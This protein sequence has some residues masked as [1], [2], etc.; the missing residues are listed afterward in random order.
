GAGAGA[1]GDVAD[2]AAAAGDGVEDE[3][4]GGEGGVGAGD[5]VH[6]GEA[7]HGLEGVAEDAGEGF[8][9]PLDVAVGGGDDDEVVGAAGDEGEFAGG[10][11]AGAKGGLGGFAFGDV[12]EGADDAGGCAVVVPGDGAGAGVDPAPV[13]VGAAEAVFGGYEGFFAAFDLLDGG[14]VG[15]EVVG[16]DAFGPFVNGGDG[17]VVGEAEEGPEAGVDVEFGAAGGPFEDADLGGVEG[18]AEALVGE[19]EAFLDAAA[20]LV[21]FDELAVGA[22]GG[23]HAV[24]GGAGEVDA[25]AEEEGD[26]E[27]GAEGELGEV[28][29]GVADVAFGG[30]EFDAQ[31]AVVD[32]EDG[33]E[34]VAG[35][36]AVV[37]GGGAVEG[38][39]GDGEGEVVAV[40]DAEVAVDG[41]EEARVVVTGGGVT[42]EDAALIDGG[43]DDEAGLAG[44]VAR[45]AGDDGAVGFGGPAHGVLADGVGGLVKAEQGLVAGAGV[46]PEGFAGGG[47]PD[48][49]ARAD[50]VAEQGDGVGFLDDGGDGVELA[51]AAG[52]AFDGGELA[53]KFKVDGGGV[54]VE[55]VL[56]GGEEVELFSVAQADPD[57][58]GGGDGGEGDGQGEP[59]GDAGVVVAVA[60]PGAQQERAAEEVEQ[61]GAADGEAAGGAPGV[62]GG[63]VEQ[64]AEQ[65]GG[66]GGDE[67]GAAEGADGDAGGGAQPAQGEHEQAADEEPEGAD[68]GHALGRLGQGDGVVGG[69]EDP[70]DVQVDAEEDLG[71]GESGEDGGEEAETAPE[72]M[73]FFQGEQDDAEDE[74]AEGGVGV[75]EQQRGGVGHELPAQ[76]DEGADADQQHG[77]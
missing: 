48:D 14:A 75:D 18:E 4:A 10:G 24:E 69:S 16:V 68:R 58:E 28:A 30:G 45:A 57:D 73:T 49:V 40:G 26:A 71:Q 2:E 61:D 31:A 62:D 39:A 6:E 59:G 53:V 11:L 67:Q 23:V 42:G 27:A 36:G 9:D 41:F 50:G 74:V 3:F 37:V 56:G 63:E 33:G 1:V 19:F 76:Q 77:Q 5:E 47:N 15:G 65:A 44:G 12:L 29:A 46:E 38:R 60:A 22:F 20:F 55:G 32:V 17:R 7:A 54:A 25:E 70:V 35:G 51:P 43:V 21:F 13:V 64:V 8:V 52:E 34:R 72:E 66:A